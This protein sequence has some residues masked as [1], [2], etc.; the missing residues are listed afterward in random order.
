MQAG[1]DDDPISAASSGLLALGVGPQ[2]RLETLGLLS[3]LLDLADERGEVL[4]DNSLIETENR[5]GIDACLEGYEWLERLDVIRRTWS[6]WLISNFE[7]HHGPAGM[8]WESM[9]VL[10]RHMEPVAVEETAPVITLPTWRRRIPAV[11]A[12]VAAGV[13]ILAGA[14]QFVPQAAVTGRNAAVQT[15]GTRAS[16]VTN[17]IT[18]AVTQATSA[19]TDATQPTLA[20]NAPAEVAGSTTTS[21]TLLPA[22]PCLGQTL[23]DLGTRSGLVKSKSTV[24]PPGV[25]PCP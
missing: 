5:L 14:T 19:A 21:T 6:G 11:A 20:T 2:R 13:A 3:A 9:A 17:P 24:L 1:H 8:T 25:L 23:N 12:S 16:G 10:R 15:E 22:V 7:A 18:A 4:L